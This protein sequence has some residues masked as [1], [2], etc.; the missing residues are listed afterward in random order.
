MCTQHNNSGKFA[1]LFK[2]PKIVRLMVSAMGKKCLFHY[3]LQPLF[4]RISF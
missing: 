2:L 4:K 1:P 3:S